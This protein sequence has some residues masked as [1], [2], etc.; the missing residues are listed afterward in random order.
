[1]ASNHGGYFPG[2]NI[3]KQEEQE[4]CANALESGLIVRD[5]AGVRKRILRTEGDTVFWEYLDHEGS[6]EQ[7]EEHSSQFAEFADTHFVVPMSRQ[8]TATAPQPR[9]QAGGGSED[10]VTVTIRKDTVYVDSEGKRVRV[11]EVGQKMVQW[12]E[13]GDGSEGVTPV[14]EF[15]KNYHLEGRAA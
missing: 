11:M 5:Q 3:T 4:Q 8:T 1:L 14:P 9:E 15:L 12:I 7:A 10:T 13:V 2:G 6:G